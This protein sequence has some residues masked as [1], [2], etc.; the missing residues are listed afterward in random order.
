MP[1][2]SIVEAPAEL[3][4]YLFE[5]WP[6]V[7]KKQVRTWLKHQAVTVNGR[8]ISQF[9]HPLVPGDTV[10][11]RSDRFAVPKT[12]LASGMKVFF[13]DAT[14][15]VIDKPEN[16]L[17]V[18]SL[19]ESEKTAYFQLTDY[20]RRGSA[21]ARDRIWIVHRLDRET[22]GLMV[23]AKTEEA[24]RA[25]QADWEQVTKRY[26]AVVEGMLPA[27]EGTLESDLDETSPFK[28]YSA[29]R[30]EGTRHAIT[31]YRVLARK[32]KR[33]LVA[34]E[35]ETGRRHQIRVQLADVRCPIIGDEKYG[36]KTNPAHRL[37]LHACGLRFT[38]P[39]T[40]KVLSFES[41]LPK[42]LA[43]LV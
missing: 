10:A 23:F 8:P 42:D 33:S 22:S 13:E 17:S 29:P 35:L 14:L 26:E 1:K 39:A 40:K 37:G 25:L 20:V 18:A 16:L 31:R 36:A 9:N 24:K 7:K 6:E 5:H 30:S 38:H 41:P 28:V 43:R 2:S 19:A 34:L 3:L 11:I 21:H 4:S 12:V 27:E 32:G 15:L